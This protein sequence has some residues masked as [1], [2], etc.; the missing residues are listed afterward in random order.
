LICQRKDRRSGKSRKSSKEASNRAKLF[1]SSSGKATL[2]RRPLGSPSL[3]SKIVK[4]PLLPLRGN[5]TSTPKHSTKRKDR[6]R[7]F[8]QTQIPSRKNQS[9]ISFASKRRVSMMLTSSI[10]Q[11]KLAK[12]PNLKGKLL[13]LSPKRSKNKI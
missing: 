9:K 1:I 6:S 13:Q 3:T 5:F 2:S 12:T 8:I 7:H 11:K 4:I 10:L